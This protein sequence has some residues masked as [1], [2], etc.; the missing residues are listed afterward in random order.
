M[1]NSD[2]QSIN[3]IALFQ[4]EGLL[5]DIDLDFGTP[6]ST[7]GETP[8]SGSS[9]SGDESGTPLDRAR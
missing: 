9:G 3:V 1:I 5:R 4:P 8:G 6:G 2:P 7:G